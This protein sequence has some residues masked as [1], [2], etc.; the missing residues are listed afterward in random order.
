VGFGWTNAAFLELLH[1]LPKETV[2]R[3]EK[4]L[5]RPLPGAR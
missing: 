2:D 3:L 1:G 5:N 4:E